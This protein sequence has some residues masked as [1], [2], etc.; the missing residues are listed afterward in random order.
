MSGTASQGGDATAKANLAS[1][2]YVASVNAEADAYAGAGGATGTGGEYALSGQAIAHATVSSYGGAQNSAL[3]VAGTLAPAE[4]QTSPVAATASSQV[5]AEGAFAS[6]ALANTGAASYP[7]DP[8]SDVTAGFAGV[9]ALPT[10]I[11]VP[12]APAGSTVLG[13]ATITAD[14]VSGMSG[15][16]KVTDTVTFSVLASSLTGALIYVDNFNELGFTGSGIETIV[17][18]PV[19]GIDTVTLVFTATAGGAADLSGTFALLDPPPS[20]ADNFNDVFGSFG[21]NGFSIGDE[22]FTLGAPPVPEPSTWAMLLIGFSALALRLAARKKTGVG[23][24]PG[25]RLIDTGGRS[26]WRRNRGPREYPP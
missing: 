2:V 15:T 23:A 20:P 24:E 19:T 16:E 1:N 12:G 7:I 3:A 14:Y 26:T 4:A 10:G 8:S 5:T 18:N 22:F 21:P 25:A 13:T 9:T 11:V 6:H 17:L